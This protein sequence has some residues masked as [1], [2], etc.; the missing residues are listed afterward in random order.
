MSNSRRIQ[1]VTSLLKKE[2]TMILMNDIKDSLI[3]ENFVSI[4]K[5]DL[6]SD[7]QYC[8]I[9]ISS[10]GEDETKDQIINNL[11]HTK[12][13]IRYFLSKRIQMR[14]IPEIS[15]KKD[16]FLDEGLSVLKLL[17]EIKKK[18]NE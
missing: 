8:K 6:S 7:L 12:T 1:K 13:S 2:I 4:S 16:R 3:V 9:Y 5:I 15:F 14:R 10:A 17:N 18:S 11:N